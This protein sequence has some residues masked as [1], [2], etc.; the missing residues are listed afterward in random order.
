MESLVDN[1]PVIL[2]QLTVDPA[3][4]Q[5]ESPSLSVSTEKLIAVA[6]FVPSLHSR[7]AVAPTAVAR[8]RDIVDIKVSYKPMETPSWITAG[9]YALREKT[10]RTI[11]SKYSSG[12][13]G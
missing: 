2:A 13:V 5:F 7:T 8:V 9:S 12:L 1:C 6:A 4:V 3:I 11:G 10:S